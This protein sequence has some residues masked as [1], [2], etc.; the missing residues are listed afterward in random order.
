MAT[1]LE[2][3]PL[4]GRTHQIRVHLNSINRP[5]AG[6]KLYGGKNNAKLAPRLMLHALS[7][8]FVGADKKIYKIETPPPSDFLIDFKNLL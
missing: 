8:E 1:L 3:Y 4:T 6:D 7:L 2:C 5:V